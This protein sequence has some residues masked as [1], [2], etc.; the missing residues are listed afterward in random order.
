MLENKIDVVVVVVVDVVMAGIVP[1]M[2]S[3]RPTLLSYAVVPKE[4]FR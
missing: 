4:L 1:F 3:S 2:T